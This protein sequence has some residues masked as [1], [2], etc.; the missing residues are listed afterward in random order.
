MHAGAGRTASARM[1]HIVTVQREQVWRDELH[2]VIDGMRHDDPRRMAWFAEDCLSSQF[3]TAWPTSQLYLD[4]TEWT[5]VMATYLG[6]PV[7]ALRQCVNHFIPTSRGTPVCDAHGLMLS[8]ATM[9]LVDFTPCHDEMALAMW[10]MMEGSGVPVRREPRYIFQRV[11]SDQQLLHDRVRTIIPDAAMTLA[12]REARTERGALQAIRP[13]PA[14]MLL[15]DVKGVHGGTRWYSSARGRHD[16]C[17]AVAARARDVQLAYRRHARTLDHH[18]HGPHSTTILDYLD[19]FTAVRGL[20]VGHYGEASPDVHALIDIAATGTARLQQGAWGART[21]AEA[22][23]FALSLH[24]RVLGVT[25][26]RAMA[27]HL[28]RRIPYVGLDY[29]QIREIAARFERGDPITMA[30]AIAPPS[31]V[32]AAPELFYA[33]QAPSDRPHGRP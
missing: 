7:P 31:Q 17:G 27:R 26:V 9:L 14:R 16:Q 10:S 18:Y 12:M 2:D 30:D 23:S 1:Q 33:Y 15:Y 6:I 8:R 22:R 21:A 3:L 4:D 11:L 24:R 13:M 20:C 19:S 25:F 28:I 32:P 5:T 29:Q